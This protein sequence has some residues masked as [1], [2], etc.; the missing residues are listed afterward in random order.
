MLTYHINS[1]QTISIR[2]V[3]IKKDN[4]KHL[5]KGFIM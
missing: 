2:K 5:F 1:L 4:I 3:D